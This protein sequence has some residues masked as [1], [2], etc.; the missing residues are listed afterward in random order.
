MYTLSKIKV[1]IAKPIV[2]GM[3]KSLERPRIHPGAGQAK[4]V[5]KILRRERVQSVLI[6]T[7]EVLYELGLLKGMTASIE[8]EGIKISLYKDVKPDPTFSIV[9][10]ALE[11][12]KENECDAVV[13]FG[14]GSV[15]DAAKAVA[16]SAANDYVDPR[17][18]KGIK[19]VKKAPITF[20]AVPTTA[21]T[22]SEV[23]MVAVVSDDQTH[24]K[25]TIIAPNLVSKH[26]VIDPELTVGLPPHITSTTGLDALTHAIEAYV[27]RYATR[28]TDE[29]ALRAFRLLTDNLERAMVEPENL[30]VR[31]DLL[32]GSLYAGKAFTRTFVGYV[33][34]F[35]HN[36][37]GKYGVPHGLGNAVLLPHIMEFS[38]D[39]AEKRLAELSDVL[40]LT[41]RHDREDSVK[42]EAFV[43][44]LF[45][46]NEKLGIPERLEDFPK[47][48]IDTIIQMAFKEA[49]GTYPVPKYLKKAQAREI[50]EKV[51]SDK[52]V[53]AP[54]KEEAAEDTNGE[55]EVVTE[56]T[57]GD[58]KE[59]A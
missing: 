46:L 56:D 47:S 12:C 8:E 17:K 54:V 35:S 53:V 19:K 50:L 45:E 40:K 13:A 48:G 44:Y 24:Q 23:T 9:D 39:K 43:K 34:A 2:K 3:I 5:G 14:G 29:F 15:L 11:V 55:V 30:E 7:D 36:I 58:V 25:A 38:K 27:S 21:G 49:H 37:G 32:L 31:R 10:E 6:V 33:H 28:E 41:A 59:V 20:V 51:C 22:G 16:G 42:A 26:T 18:L 4:H 52:P 57:N 1:T